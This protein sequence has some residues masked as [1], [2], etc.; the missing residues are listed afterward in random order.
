MKYGHLISD[1]HQYIE[2]DQTL[3]K[4]D[5][6][7]EYIRYMGI[8]LIY[9]HNYYGDEF[10]SFLLYGERSTKNANFRPPHIRY[11][12]LRGRYTDFIYFWRHK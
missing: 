6:P 1:A 10:H 7:Y 2:M 3:Q 9:S 4:K 12:N 11:V 5:A 8:L